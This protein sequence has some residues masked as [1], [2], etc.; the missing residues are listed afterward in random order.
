MQAMGSKTTKQS[1][2]RE[3]PKSACW[4]VSD[5]HAES[6]TDQAHE[7]DSFQGSTWTQQSNNLNSYFFK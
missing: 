2:I 7:L 4:F 5:F 1:R 3:L 6:R